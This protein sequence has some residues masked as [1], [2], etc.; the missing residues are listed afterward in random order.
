MAWS[1]HP[2]VVTGQSWTT[3]DQNTY[4]KG[5]LDTLFPYADTDPYSLQ[6]SYSESTAILEK[7]SCTNKYFY[8]GVNSSNII[9]FISLVSNRL[10]Q[11]T[12]WGTSISTSGGSNYTS[13]SVMIQCGVCLVGAFGSGT[14]TQN[15]VFPYSYSIPPMIFLQS[16]LQQQRKYVVPLSVTSTGFQITNTYAFSPQV[17]WLS[18]GAI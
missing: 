16:N 1:T 17:Q 3:S 13:E 15:I 9:G 12:N 18:I 14:E 5:N 2:T 7:A 6:V 10:G 4:V 11:S 8:L